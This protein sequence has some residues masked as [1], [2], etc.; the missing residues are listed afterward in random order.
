MEL[1]YVKFGK[2]ISATRRAKHI[3]QEQLAEACE[4]S[5]S[6]LSYIENGDRKGS[7]DSIYRISRVLEVPIDTFLLGQGNYE[8]QFNNAFVDLFEGCSKYECQIIYEVGIATKESL[9]TN[10]RLYHHSR[11][12]R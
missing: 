3:T 12:K 4:I 8:F 5:V 2:Q 7:F 1:D 6:F 11:N 10:R 9:K